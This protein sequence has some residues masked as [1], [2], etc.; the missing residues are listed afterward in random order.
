ML[1]R[2][3][4]TGFKQAKNADKLSVVKTNLILL[5]QHSKL[6]NST[7]EL[8]AKF[9]KASSS[10]FI[11]KARQTAAL[12]FKDVRNT[13]PVEEVDDSCNPIPVILCC[14]YVST[15]GQNIYSLTRKTELN[16]TNC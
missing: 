2:S 16:T 3:G 13:W 7:N 12:F 9:F 5:Q 14:T 15:T 11:K 1:T 8:R 6:T 10:G 4:L